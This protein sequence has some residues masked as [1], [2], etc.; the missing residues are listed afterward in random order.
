MTEHKAVAYSVKPPENYRVLKARRVRL[1]ALYAAIAVVPLALLIFLTLNAELLAYTVIP[2]GVFCFVAI[3][4]TWPKTRPE[5]DYTVEAGVLSLAAVYGGRIRRSLAEIELSQALLIAPNNGSYENRVKDL[6]PERTVNAVFSEEQR[7]F[8]V[9]Y[10]DENDVTAIA[11]IYA[12]EDAQKVFH[13][14]CT[15]TYLR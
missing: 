13:R 14:A 12:T 10:R 5:Y 3:R 1:I 8:F 4:M 7:N 15:K 6:A 9:V 11:Y 2:V